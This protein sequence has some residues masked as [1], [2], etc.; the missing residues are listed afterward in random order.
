MDH[1]VLY[2]SAGKSTPLVTRLVYYI[3]QN[4]HTVSRAGI[5]VAT[6]PLGGSRHKVK[7]HVEGSTRGFCIGFGKPD[8]LVKQPS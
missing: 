5:A 7:F 1:I 3:F 2:S 6:F 4:K 8:F